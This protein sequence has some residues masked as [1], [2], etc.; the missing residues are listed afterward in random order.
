M[1]ITI[2]GVDGCGKS[3]VADR[4][5][6]RIGAMRLDFP[7]RSTEI[8]GLIDKAL[9]NE[10]AAIPAA[11]LQCLFAANKYEFANL[12]HA[13]SSGSTKLVL[14][15]YWQSAVVYGSGFDGLGGEWV[16]SLHEGLPPALLNILIDVEPETAIA[17][18]IARGEPAEL[19]ETMDA[20]GVIVDGYRSLWASAD[21]DGLD[22]G[23]WGVVDGDAPLDFVIQDVL[24][25]LELARR[26]VDGGA[27]VG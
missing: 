7:V 20:A 22:H 2:E 16:R 9:V 4:V 13:A 3:T 24:W 6:K 15:R 12:L 21:N 14:G 19:Y 10:D 27:Q 17:R 18:R 8:G 23:V 5:A 25:W 26:W 11:A 1:L